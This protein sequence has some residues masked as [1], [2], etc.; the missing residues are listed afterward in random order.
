MEW[1]LKEVQPDVMEK[2]A[3]FVWEEVICMDGT[4]GPGCRTQECGE[5]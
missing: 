4:E 2:Y 1:I 5:M 3:R